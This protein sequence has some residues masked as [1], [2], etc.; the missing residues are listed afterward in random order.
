[1]K[2]IFGQVFNIR[3]GELLVTLLMLLYIYLVMVTYYFLKPARDSLFL[4]EIGWKQLPIVFVLIALVA[5]PVNALYSKAGRKLKMNKLINYTTLILIICLMI[6]RWVIS[7]GDTWA[8]YTFYIWV[9]IYGV[10]ATAQFWLFANTIYTP[11]QA[12]RLFVLLNLGAILGAFSGGKI[13]KLVVT[14]FSVKTENLLFFC[15]V[16]LGICIFIINGI[17]ALKKKEIETA[18]VK[19]RRQEKHQKESIAQVFRSIK[20]SR[21]LLLIV[22]VIAMTMATGTFVDTQFKGATEMHFRNI[23]GNPDEF[24]DAEKAL[25]QLSLVIFTGISA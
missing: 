25:R 8:M 24:S 14:T 15:M 13:T 21:Y 5:V 23:D 18:P 17:W 19:I 12:K 20:S 9:S 6:M 16:F 1:M 2:K 10:L 3:K 22:G 11:T 4:S 7:T